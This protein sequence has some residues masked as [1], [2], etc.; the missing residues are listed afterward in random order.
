MPG[1]MTETVLETWS[2]VYTRSCDRPGTAGAAPSGCRWPF[3]FFVAGSSLATKRRS[4]LDSAWLTATGTAGDGA[5]EARRAWIF[6][7]YSISMDCSVMTS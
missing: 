4:L 3:A 1:S 2:P 5:F 7:R 6:W